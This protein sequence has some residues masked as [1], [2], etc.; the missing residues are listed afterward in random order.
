MDRVA[1]SVSQARRGLAT[2]NDEAVGCNRVVVPAASLMPERLPMGFET[3][4]RYYKLPRY[5]ADTKRMD[6]ST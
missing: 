6:V 5:G 2:Q 4:L 1:L 3:P